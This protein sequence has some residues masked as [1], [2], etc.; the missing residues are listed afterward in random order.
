MFTFLTNLYKFINPIEAALS[1]LFR[2]EW[3]IF[4]VN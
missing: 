3:N 1:K 2:M 4:K